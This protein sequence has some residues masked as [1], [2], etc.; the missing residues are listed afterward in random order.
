MQHAAELVNQAKVIDLS[1]DFRLHDVRLYEKYYGRS[2]DA[3][4]WKA[5]YGLP[6]LGLRAE[7]RDS[8]LVANPGCYP[9]ASILALLPLARAGLNRRDV[10]AVVDAKSGVSGAGRSKKET[11][12]LFSEMS[13]SFK[14]YAPIGHRHTPEI[15]QAYGS[16]VRFTP[17][18]LPIARGI[19]A[20]A[21][22]ALKERVDLVELY[23]EMYRHEPFVHVQATP[24][25][26]KQ[27]RGSNMCVIYPIY[28]DHTG[29]AVVCSVIDN[30]VKGAAGQAIQ[31][32]NIMMGLPETAGLPRNGLWP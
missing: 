10:P 19:H 20:T 30:L 11:D 18:L 2:H 9:T 28:D 22:V 12:F 16:A 15:E 17:H 14:A 21:H 27:V 3:P 32:M 13:D 23:T 1:A 31:N 8:N 29:F 24:P 5:V 4:D 6:E 26:T 7:I 25:S